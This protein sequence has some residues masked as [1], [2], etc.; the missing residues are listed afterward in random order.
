[1]EKGLTVE[2]MIARGH[3][4]ETVQEVVARID[5]NEYKR[6]QAPVG[7]KI[8]PRAFGKDWRLPISSRRERDF[9]G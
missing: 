6:R 1:M 4:A 5:S 9:L 3:P 8:S 7:V 2:E